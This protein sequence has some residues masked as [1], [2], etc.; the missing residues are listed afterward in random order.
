[1]KNYLLFFSILFSGLTLSAQTLTSVRGNGNVSI[2][3]RNLKSE[4]HSIE[5]SNG[6]DVY[7]THGNTASIEVEADENLHQVITTDVSKGVLK[8]STN[9]SIRKSTKRSVYVTYT[10]L[11]SISAK[12]GSEVKSKDLLKSQ[13]LDLH[14]SSGAEIKLNILS[15]SVTSSASSGGEIDL[16]GKSINIEAEASSGGE[17][18]AKNLSVLHAQAKAS[19]GGEVKVNAQESLKAGASSG[20]EVQYYG[21]PK[22]TDIRAKVSG[23][24]KKK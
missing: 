1:M 12:S 8:I 4:F 11:Q 21:N 3:E 16:E 15:E 24:V 22:N 14:A 10:E 5:A 7:L 18:D 23:S 13:N 2:Q 19:S 17:I 9:K 6:I 20:G